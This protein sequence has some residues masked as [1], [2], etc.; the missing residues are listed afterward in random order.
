MYFFILLDIKQNKYP[1]LTMDVPSLFGD[2]LLDGVVHRGGW[3]WRREH[4]GG[5]RPWRDVGFACGNRWLPGGDVGLPGGNWWLAWRWCDPFWRQKHF[6]RCSSCGDGCC[7]GNLWEDSLWSDW[8]TAGGSGSLLVQVGDVVV[9][10][11][12]QF[13]W[14]RR[15]NNHL[16]NGWN[17]KRMQMEHWNMSN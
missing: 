4:G 7:F 10:I 13:S 14:S 15:V 5:H 12:R 2:L 1:A 16:R 8:W 3:W 6:G 17:N 11:W 9:M